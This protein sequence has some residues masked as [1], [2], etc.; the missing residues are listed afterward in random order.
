MAFTQNIPSVETPEAPSKVA[1]MPPGNEEF[2]DR[3]TPAI[4]F[5]DV[6]L[7][8]DDHKVLDGISFT[9]MKGET[10]II[11]GGRAAANRRSSNWSSVYSNPT[12]V[13]S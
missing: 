7:A 5:R 4:E 6:H 3:I 13:A 2:A 8:F 1:D 10:K 9:V 11:L 12:P